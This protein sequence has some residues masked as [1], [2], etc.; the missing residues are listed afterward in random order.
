MELVRGNMRDV[1]CVKR[2]IE[3]IVEEIQYLGDRME[4]VVKCV[5]SNVVT[6]ADLERS[7]DM[8]LIDDSFGK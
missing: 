3:D 6:T 1:E 7:G 5:E 4:P 2:Q 8:M